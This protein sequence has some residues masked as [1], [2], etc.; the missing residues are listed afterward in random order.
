MTIKMKILR[1]SSTWKKKGFNCFSDKG[2]LYG[3]IIMFV[4]AELSNG[5]NGY[6]ESLISFYRERFSHNFI[7]VSCFKKY[8]WVSMGT[9][10]KKKAAPIA[11]K[12]GNVIKGKNN[13]TVTS[14]FVQ[15]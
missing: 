1:I 7:V 9:R 2:A 5:Y 12:V 13:L 14:V 4:Q 8:G 15:L 10:L 6:H 3:L 11:S